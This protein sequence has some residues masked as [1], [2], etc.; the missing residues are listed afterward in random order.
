MDVR[1]IKR[2]YCPKCNNDGVF[3]NLVDEGSREFVRKECSLCHYIEDK[4]PPP[5]PPEPETKKVFVTETVIKSDI[6]EKSKTKAVAK[7]KGK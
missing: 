4:L 3:L 5:A 2:E 6:S 1:V 7:K